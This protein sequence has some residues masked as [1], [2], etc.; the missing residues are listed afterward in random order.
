MNLGDKMRVKVNGERVMVPY[1]RENFAT[2]TRTSDSVLVETYLG[3][4]VIWDGNSFLEV[5]VPA[6]YKGKLS[7]KRGR[8]GNRANY[9]LVEH[10]RSVMRAV[11]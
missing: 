8:Y 4:K 11:R 7:L 6:S 1:K 3:V 2:V 5:S 9:Q 10:Y